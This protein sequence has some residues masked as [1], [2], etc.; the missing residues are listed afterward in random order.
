MSAPS[1][2]A[3]PS[4]VG[5]TDPAAAERLA[6]EQFIAV[7]TADLALAEANVGPDFVNRR[8]GHEPLAARG[9]GPTALHATALWLN[10]AFSGLHFE[11]HDTAVH[12][13][14]VVAWVTLHGVHTGPFVVHDS[15]DGAVTEVFPPTGR[16]FATRQVH[17]FRVA[18]GVI[19]EHDAI[20][21]DLELAKQVGWI[22]PRPGYLLRMRAA[23][24]RARRTAA[25]A[26]SRTSPAAE[27]A[28]IPG[29]TPPHLPSGRGDAHRANSTTRGPATTASPGDLDDLR[30]GT[31]D[32]AIMG[33]GTVAWLTIAHILKKRAARRRA[34]RRRR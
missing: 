34:R 1:A 26:D 12:D 13:D 3:T 18:D 8:A 28:D 14:L 2:P 20:R 24:R 5:S 4:A 29:V 22:P 23:L 27:Q 25:R 33:D 17:W 16:P 32:L 10:D 21:D 9:R 19:T 11:V 31:H 15:P 6:R 30:F 7:E